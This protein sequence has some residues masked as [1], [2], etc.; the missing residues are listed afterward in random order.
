M[1]DVGTVDAR[2]LTGTEDRAK[3]LEVLYRTQARRIYNLAYRFVGNPA[4]AEELLQEI[5]LQAHRRLDDFRQEAALSTWLH[6]LAVNRCLDHLRSRAARQTA[7]TAPLNDEAPSPLQTRVS[8][9]PITRLDL[10]QAIASLPDG[11]RTV[12][13]LHDVEG[14]Q[15]REIAELLGIAVGT[16]KSQ[17]HKARLKLRTLLRRT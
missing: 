1:I 7:L 14:Y 3:T 13:I 12:F 9:D 17:V 11:Y 2:L 4:D 15:H 5:F 10:E 8:T 16:S 6:R